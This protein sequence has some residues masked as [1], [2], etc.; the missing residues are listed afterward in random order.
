MN[1]HEHNKEIK[2]AKLHVTMFPMK[3]RKAILH[4]CTSLM[5]VP[6][7]SHCPMIPVLRSSLAGIQKSCVN[8]WQQ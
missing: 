4:S 3:V 5:V 7:M 1:I 2:V 6:G 8:V